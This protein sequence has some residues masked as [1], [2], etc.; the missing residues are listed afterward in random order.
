MMKH[1]YITVYLSMMT[2]VLLALVLTVIE[3]VRM[4]TI[5][6]Q[7]ECVTDMALDSALAEYHRELLKQ[8]DLFFIDTS[9]G[10]GFPSCIN[11]AE[12]IQKYMNLNFQP[13]TVRDIPVGKDLTGLTADMVT[14]IEAA[15]AADDNCA[16]LKQQIADY[17]RN[18]WGIGYLNR[19]KKQADRISG[20]G[21]LSGNW[22]NRRIQTERHVKN[23]ILQKQQEEKD[24][25]VQNVELPSDVVNQARSMGVLAHASG[26]AAKLS[27]KQIVTEKLFS[28]REDPLEGT[29]IPEGKTS[30]SG[31]I[32]TGLCYRYILE[33]CGYY[34]H[35]KE[36][37]AFSYQVEYILAGKNNDM[38][39]LRNVANQLLM[40]R[41]TANTIYLF[42][43]S[44]KRAEA[45][46]TAL[47][48]TSLLGLPEL[49]EPVTD[50][51]L[52]AWAYAESVQ[53]LRILF[54]GGKIPFVKDDDTWNT[55]YRH[56]LTFQNH[57]SEYHSVQSGMSYA[58]YLEALLYLK[59]ENQNLKRLMD[60]IEADIRMTPGNNL[61]RI[62]GCVNALTVEAKVSSRFGYQYEIIRKCRYE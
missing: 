8:Y 36:N 37:S 52:F 61:F 45:E 23:T 26:N 6:T 5:R 50:L 43:D 33:K 58:D 34:G 24:E 53:D 3:G 10:S 13:L 42:G 28:S 2:G 62:D 44:G 51:I 16:V 49:T 57:L 29:G 46:G 18:R 55:P 41:E 56:L 15:A 7:T 35:V 11:T 54:D 38:E 20:E 4:H 31:I 40:I 47:I 1:G 14:V 39:N 60:V 12:H 59:Q 25:E 30:D 32:D 21:Y 17:M 9:Y 19:A 22:E 48:L 27:R